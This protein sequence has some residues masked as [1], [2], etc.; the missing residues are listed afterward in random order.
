[1]PIV[2]D[3]CVHSELVPGMGTVTSNHKCSFNVAIYSKSF[4]IT[5]GIRKAESR[6]DCNVIAKNSCRTDAA[7]ICPST[8]A[9]NPQLCP[10]VGG[11]SVD[12]DYASFHKS[13]V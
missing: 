7:F 9:A 8:S 2:L 5:C 11:G 13:S 4:G 1:M 6:N 3:V 12:M 10:A